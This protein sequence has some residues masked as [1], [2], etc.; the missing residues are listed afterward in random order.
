MV[1]AAFYHQIHF[2]SRISL[3]ELYCKSNQ[4]TLQQLV[5]GKIWFSCRYKVNQNKLITLHIWL[6]FCRLTE[7]WQTGLTRHWVKNMSPLADKC[8]DKHPP[9]ST[10]AVPIKLV[11]LTGAFLVLGLGTGMSLL[12]FLV[13][14]VYSKFTWV[15]S[16]K[17][18]E[19]WHMRASSNTRR[20]KLCQKWIRCSCSYR[21]S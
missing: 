11:D 8:F 9:K 14:K 13:E 19:V 3:L 21:R 17:V 20:Q 6:Y 1:S 16:N 5:L 4:S 15:Q 2:R 12:T 7:L 10:T 18:T